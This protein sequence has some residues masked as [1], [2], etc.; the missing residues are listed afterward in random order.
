MTLAHMIDGATAQLRQ[1]LQMVEEIGAIMI[2]AEQQSDMIIGRI[3]GL[4][5]YAQAEFPQPVPIQAQ[6]YAP[7]PQQQYYPQ[8]VAVPQQQPQQARAPQQPQR[9][10][11]RP[12][13]VYQ[14]TPPQHHHAVNTHA[15]VVRHVAY[16]PQ[17]Q[18]P[19][20][21]PEQPVGF[22]QGQLTGLLKKAERAHDVLTGNYAP[23]P[24]PVA[25]TG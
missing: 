22:V 16:P 20:P 5:R 1:Q 25:K 23:P 24:I 19:A 21:E 14:D 9:Q 7:Q 2:E 12:A 13:P 18:Q 6:Q 8:S 17:P 11:P 15:P 3:T 4:A 10:H